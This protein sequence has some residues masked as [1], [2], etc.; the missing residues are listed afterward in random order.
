MR[1]THCILRNIIIFAQILLTAMKETLSSISA[2]TGFSI[3]TISRVL[4]GQSQKYRISNKTR[5][6]ILEEAKRCDYSPNI[7]A[8]NLRTNKTNT[9]G[10]LMPSVANPYFA[11]MASVIIAEAN[12]R[13]YTT[14]VIDAQESELHQQTNMYSL[15]SRKVDGIIA[16]PC[17]NDSSIFEEVNRKHIPIILVDRFFEGSGLSY[18]TTNN[19]LGGLEGTRNLIRNGHKD[20]ACIQ[21]ATAS[22]PNR[23]RV[24]GYM[25]ALKRAGLEDRAII[26]GNEFSLQNGYLE[27]KLLLG[28]KPRPTA[29]FTLSNTIGLGAIKA[30]REAGLKIPDDI[31]IISFDNNVYMDYL[32]PP[33]SR[34]SQPVEEM[35]KLATKL[36][37]ECIESKKRSNI[38][39]ELSPELISRE[40]VRNL[41]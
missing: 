13:N 11:E 16:A 34:V 38:Q 3:T 32:T 39:L 41:D 27:T 7:I 33:V 28:R 19:Y 4:S 12:T 36:L 26:V 35:A 5:D 22:T 17:G 2:R 30:I 29:I 24:A 25:E 1:K 9:I 6:L 31:S 18:V 8:Q 14:I 20:I 23:K 40:S 37:F 21:G 15:I 10:V